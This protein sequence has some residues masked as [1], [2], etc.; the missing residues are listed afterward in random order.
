MARLAALD[1]SAIN[2]KLSKGVGRSPSELTLM[3]FLVKYS[4]GGGGGLTLAAQADRGRACTKAVPCCTVVGQGKVNVMGWI[5]QQS[6]EHPLVGHHGVHR[7][8]I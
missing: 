8:P 4:R 6:R 5:D 3:L 7:E 1:L 2:N